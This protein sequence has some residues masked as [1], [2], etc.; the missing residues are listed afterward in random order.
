MHGVRVGGLWVV[1]SDDDFPNRGVGDCG[2]GRTV[3]LLTSHGRATP[4]V[5]RT[6]KKSALQDR[7]N[8]YEYE[9]VSSS[10]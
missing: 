10:S 5:W 4:L 7:R 3:Y 9:L 2:G 6:V 8:Q 1:L